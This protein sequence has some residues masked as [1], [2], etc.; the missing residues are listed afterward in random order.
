VTDEKSVTA[1]MM[2]LAS[3]VVAAVDRMPIMED[4]SNDMKVAALRIATEAYVQRISRDVHLAM[5]ANTMRGR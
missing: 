3:G 5:L 4:V 2:S 1:E